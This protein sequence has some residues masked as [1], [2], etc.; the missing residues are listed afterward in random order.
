LINMQ[1]CDLC[2]EKTDVIYIDQFTLVLNFNNLL[3]IIQY[4]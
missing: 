2:S 1:I 4:R 3:D